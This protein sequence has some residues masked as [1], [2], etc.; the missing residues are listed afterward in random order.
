MSGS[1]QDVARLAG[2]SKTL[3]SR[4][5]NGQSGVSE[6]SRQKIQAAM[7]ELHYEP[8]A[9]ARSLVLR[10]TNTVGVVMDTLCERYF[11]EL[12][13]G[14]EA[15]AD[16]IRYNVIFSS[17]RN[18]IQYKERAVRYFM[19]G[20]TDGVILYGSRLE[21]EPLIHRLARSDFPF[22]VI[23]NTFPALDINNIVVDN[24]FGSA[25]AVDHLF[26]CGCRRISH[27]T[28]GVKH[29]ASMDRRDGYIMA[30]QHH[31]V[32]VDDRMIIQADFDI[33]ETYQMMKAMLAELPQ[34]E[35]PDAYY[36]GSDN[37]AYG[38]MLALQEAGYRVPEDVMVIGFD[39]DAPP[40]NHHFKP[41]TTL[42]QPLY[43]M[44]V[45][46]MELLLDSIQ[47]PKGKKDRVVYYPELVI[48]E[49]TR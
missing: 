29:R 30:M 38:L 28:G 3:V 24:A 11:F 43:Q 45:S 23:E 35:L 49:T 16:Q 32:A 36:C 12:I 10:S 5:I 44:G 46:A 15:G 9:L 2:V 19:Q 39:D 37:T 7:D 40:A 13:N 31:G 20:R 47:N 27:V 18:Q 17:G 26:R 25:I 41:L 48:R 34:G 22:V 4:M 21:D 42:A 1:L 8:N 33:A 14:L 6:K